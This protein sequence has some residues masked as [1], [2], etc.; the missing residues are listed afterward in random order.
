MRVYPIRWRHGEMT[1][2]KRVARIIGILLLLHL[3]AGLILPFVLLQPLGSPRT[4]LAVAAAMSN[5]VRIAVMILFAGSAL[6]IGISCAALRLFRTYSTA[7]A[8]W[9]LALAAASF[10]LQT[11]DNGHLLSMVS[12]SQAY[13]EAGAAN[14]RTF[15]AAGLAVG[16]LRKWSH[17]SFLLTVGCWIILLNSF[18][19]RFRLVPR[20]L[21]GFCVAA[22]V[23]QLSGVTL[24]GLWEYTPE[25]RL[26]MPLA[27]AY[28]ALAMWLIFKGLD[29]QPRSADP[30]EATGAGERRAGEYPD[31][32]A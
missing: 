32:R 9:L 19:F 25:S 20:W 31:L 28:V 1:P 14:A 12:V 26:A 30:H 21:A 18:L 4:F 7:T 2:E 8:Y 27:P 22:A 29:L 6:P 15:Q 10:V 24:R 5:Q 11:V 23:G 13:A 16:A 3:A 17:Y